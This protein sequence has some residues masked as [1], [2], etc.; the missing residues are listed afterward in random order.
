MRQACSQSPSLPFE[1]SSASL[2]LICA[3][4]PI[5]W[6]QVSISGFQKVISTNNAAHDP[7]RQASGGGRHR[8]Q[9]AVQVLGCAA[10]LHEQVV[11]ARVPSQWQTRQ[12]GDHKLYSYKSM[13]RASDRATVRPRRWCRPARPSCSPPSSGLSGI[14]PS[15]FFS[16]G[17]GF[18]WERKLQGDGGDATQHVCV[19]RLGPRVSIGS[20]AHWAL[21]LFFLFRLFLFRWFCIWRL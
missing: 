15:H 13:T 8:D 2:S 1:S 18:E 19:I 16:N 10:H 11:G 3:I 4:M 20:R 9:Q 12:P 6:G 14:F 7:S 5:L 17:V 21:Y